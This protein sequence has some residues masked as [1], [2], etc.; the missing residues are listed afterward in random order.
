MVTFDR[1]LGI[2]RAEGWEVTGYKLDKWQDEPSE[3]D[4]RFRIREP[5]EA[6]K[7]G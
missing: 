2:L 1:L 4:I 3:T 7:N 5:K 6:I